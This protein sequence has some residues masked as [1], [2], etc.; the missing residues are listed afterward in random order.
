[1]KVAEANLVAARARRAAATTYLEGVQQVDRDR[2]EILKRHAANYRIER[3]AEIAMLESRVAMLEGKLE[4]AKSVAAR[5][6]SVAASG[7]RSRDYRDDAQ[8]RLAEAELALAAERMT[9][10]RARRYRV[11]ADNDILPG[12]PTARASTGPMTTARRPRSRSSARG[13]SSIAPRPRSGK[14]STPSRRR[15]RSSSCITA[16]RCWRQRARRCAA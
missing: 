4:A 13:S 15:A 16:R 11:A 1:M 10:E 6:Q 12:R 8:I 2:R 5:G 7:Y 14:P 9:L 3:D